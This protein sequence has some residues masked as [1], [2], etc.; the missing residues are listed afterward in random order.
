M[1]SIAKAYFPED[2]TAKLPRSATQARL[3]RMSGARLSLLAGAPWGLGVNCRQGACL[4]L[5]SDYH[6]QCYLQLVGIL[7]PLLTEPKP[8]SSCAEA[9]LPLRKSKDL[10]KVMPVHSAVIN[11]LL[12]YIPAMCQHT[13]A[14]CEPT[15]DNLPYSLCFV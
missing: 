2:Y 6:L 12:F 8:Q 10:G 4:P 1:F 14:M 3:Q 5:A 7:F 11:I 15:D 9:L 13:D